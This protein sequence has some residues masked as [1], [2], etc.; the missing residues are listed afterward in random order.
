MGYDKEIQANGWYVN[1]TER[2]GLRIDTSPEQAGGAS[3]G[4][5]QNQHNVVMTGWTEEAPGST[6][7]P[8]LNRQAGNLN[9]EGGTY[10]KDGTHER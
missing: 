1:Q 8:C 9:S 7:H 10:A 5:Q 4:W 2:E 6:L 3:C